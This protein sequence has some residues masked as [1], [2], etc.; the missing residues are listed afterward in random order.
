M[1]FRLKAFSLHLLSSATVLTLILGSLYFGWYRWP[2]WHLTDVTT[3]VLV[4][5]C[6]DVVLGPTLTFIIANQKK[7]RRE[8]ARD[9]GVIVV[10][11]L[12]AL[13][14]GS[15]S[16]WNGRPL[17]YAFSES[18]LQ[19]VQAYDID[20][21]EAEI[22]R[23]QNP[24]LAPHWYSLPRWIWAPLPQ[25]PE[26][27]RKIVTAAITGGDDVI[28]MPKYFKP[29]EDGLPSLRGKLKKVDDVAY[30]AKSEKKKLEERMKAAGLPDDQANTMPLTGRGHPLLAVFDP[31]TLKIMGTIK[32]K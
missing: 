16:L 8:L 32:A 29:W 28:S 15:V 14:Y 22:G 7:S 31:V 25:N 27:S 19:L 6:V 18:V 1:R 26:E 13:I 12:C 23:Q 21:K 10:V 2:G 11:Q 30:F 17:Y 4:M 20:D 5:V 3:V 24:S 9:I